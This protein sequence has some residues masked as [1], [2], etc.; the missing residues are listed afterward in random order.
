[1]VSHHFS[2]CRL[3]VQPFESE[4]NANGRA[5]GPL[6]STACITRAAASLQPGLAERLGLRPEFAF[7]PMLTGGLAPRRYNDHLPSCGNDRFST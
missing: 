1:M 4:F 2:D 7:H 3:K 6:R 5:V